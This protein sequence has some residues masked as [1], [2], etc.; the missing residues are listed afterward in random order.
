MIERGKRII[1]NSIFERE[2]N[3]F[4]KRIEDS[5]EYEGAMAEMGEFV[6]CLGG[7]LEKDD[8]TPNMP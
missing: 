2:Q 7:I 4:L 5:M 6:K 8:R 1:D 3:N